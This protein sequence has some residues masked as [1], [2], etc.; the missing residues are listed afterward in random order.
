MR[1]MAEPVQHPEPGPVPAGPDTWR[2]AVRTATGGVR[3]WFSSVMGDNAYRR[4]VHHLAVHHPGKVVPSEKQ[5]WRDRYAEM[6]R[7][8]GAR[9]C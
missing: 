1:V 8:P 5:Y 2:G 7:N 3:W 9:C 4:Y 6:D